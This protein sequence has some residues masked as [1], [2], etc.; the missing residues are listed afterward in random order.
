M[1]EEGLHNS[2]DSEAMQVVNKGQENVL[3]RKKSIDNLPALRSKALLHAH[4]V[5][6]GLCFHL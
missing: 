4:H 5:V 3:Y 6:L 2:Q 1:D